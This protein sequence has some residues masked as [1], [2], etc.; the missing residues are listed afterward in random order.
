MTFRV[1]KSAQPGTLKLIVLTHILQDT[2]W[3]IWEKEWFWGHEWRGKVGVREL[4]F[5]AYPGAR[6]GTKVIWTV[7]QSNNNR[8][9]FGDDSHGLQAGTWERTC[10][11]WVPV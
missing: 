7:G 5:W 10:E 11:F 9:L 3:V 8:A 2:I 1:F 6:L 4:E